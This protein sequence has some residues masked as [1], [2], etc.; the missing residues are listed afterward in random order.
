MKKVLIVALALTL[1]IGSCACAE[2][3]ETH[4]EMGIVID[5]QQ[6]E[7]SLWLVLCSDSNGDVWGFYEDVE[8]WDIGDLALMEMY[9]DEVIGVEYLGHVWDFQYDKA[10]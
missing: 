2:E 3:S 6:I 4:L 10:L 9:K 8:P 7:E 1:A 5:C